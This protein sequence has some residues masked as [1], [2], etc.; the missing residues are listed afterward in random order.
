MRSV[1]R[2]SRNALASGWVSSRTGWVA[3]PESSKGVDRFHALRKASRRATQTIRSRT[4]ASAARLMIRDVFICRSLWLVL[5]L[6]MGVV[7]EVS[8]ADKNEQ[9]VPTIAVLDFVNRA[10]G[11]GHD[12]LGKG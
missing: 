2:I 5:G 3:R 4:G 8:A 7:G 6:M 9:R 1:V 12:W 10:A 11:D